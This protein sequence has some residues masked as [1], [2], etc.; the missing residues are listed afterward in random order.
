MP[1]SS[2]TDDRGRRTTRRTAIVVATV[3]LVIAVGAGVGVLALR[4]HA[5]GDVASTPPSV[6]TTTVTRADLSDTRSLN[7]TLGFGPERVVKGAGEGVVTRLPKVGDTV[8][9]GKPLYRVNDRPVPVLFGGTPLFRT[10]D[11]P[12]LVGSDVR[13]VWDNLTALGY[14][15]GSQ[16]SRGTDG[17]KIGTGQAV[18]TGSLVAA[19]KK[20]QKAVGLDPTG[21]IGVGQVAVLSGPARVSAVKALPGD[22]VAGELLAVTE[23]VKLVTVPVGATEVGTITVGAAVVV[24]LP[25]SSEIPAKVASISQTVRGGGPDGG[26]GQGSPPTVD[27]LVA[28]TRAADVAKLDAAAVQVRFTTSVHKDVLAVPVGAL[29]AL[30]EG[31]H[32]LQLPDGGLVAVE[33]GMFARG[34]V[35]ISGTGVTEGLDV[36]TAS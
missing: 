23:K 34:L 17:T 32:A 24:A 26:T 4:R 18:L 10:L 3:T 16:P 33:T 27:V 21:T 7:G 15:T 31:G 28:P 19:I 35:E 11:K 1:R 14:H 25:D 6:A 2:P 29:V 36:V 12:G 8:A 5:D 9:R 22:P 13:I 30:R 20:W